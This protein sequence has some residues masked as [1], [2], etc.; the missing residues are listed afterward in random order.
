MRKL[1]VI[2]LFGA[3]GVGKS[4]AAAGLFYYMKRDGFSVEQVTEYAKYLILS[5]NE[6]TL[7]NE[8]GKLLAEQ[9]HKQKILTD[10]YDYA[11]TDSPLPL[12]SFYNENLTKNFTP[13]NFDLFDQFDNINLFLS[14]D[15]SGGAIYEEEGR[16]HS[17]EESIRI[18]G[19]L[20]EYLTKHGIGFVD[21]IVDRDIASHLLKHIQRIEWIEREVPMHAQLHD[22]VALALVKQFTETKG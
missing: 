8:P 11:I 1:K 14:R 4:S 12:V 5:G 16:I 18:N 19:E 2:N 17:R 15:L 10:M 22:P 13:Y 21:F 7:L 9:F 6:K 20:K 3:P